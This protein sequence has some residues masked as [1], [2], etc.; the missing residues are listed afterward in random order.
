MRASYDLE[1][2]HHDGGMAGRENWVIIL[3]IG[4]IHHLLFLLLN[5][6]LVP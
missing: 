1:G 5:L 6:D 3:G 2:L 4:S